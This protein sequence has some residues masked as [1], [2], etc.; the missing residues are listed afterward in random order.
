MDRVRDRGRRQARLLRAH[1]A[2]EIRTARLSTGVSQRH[3]ADVTGLSQT[4]ISRIEREAR[5]N[6][7]FDEASIVCAAL[8]L[9]LHTKAYPA[10]S[11]V[12]D[13]AQLRLLARFRPEIS[14]AF[15]WRTEVP[16]GD[17]GD[18]R[19]WDVLLEGPATI[20]VDAETRLHDM[21]ALQRR[22]ELKWRDS[23][24]DRLVLLIAGTHHNRDVLR[25]HRAALLSTFPLG[26][27]DVLRSLR[28]GEAP[29]A[30]GIVLL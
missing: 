10:G 2:A 28:T 4:M 3:V 1:L 24:T 16:V 19:A 11:P 5:P 8:G 15:T 22:L 14:D 26:T 29:S 12:R 9:K 6:L 23:G 25:E 17:R 13:A 30:N 27:A 20:G 7:T 18:L 21:Q